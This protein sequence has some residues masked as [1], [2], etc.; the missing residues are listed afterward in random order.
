[1]LSQYKRKKNTSKT[2]QMNAKKKPHNVPS[3]VKIL[4]PTPEVVLSESDSDF[5]DSSSDEYEEMLLSSMRIPKTSQKEQSEI[6]PIEPAP[7]KMKP[8]KEPKKTLETLTQDTQEVTTPV[9]PK[10]KPKKK[11]R[12]PRTVVNKYY[13]P[14]DKSPVKKPIVEQSRRVSYIGLGGSISL[15]SNQL[16]N[17]II[18][19]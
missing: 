18:N 6:K 11:R 1:M 12:R 14:R 13:M 19:F 7:V 5:S 16:R 15:Q 2:D 17:R 4:E 3:E 8:T 10:S 9:T